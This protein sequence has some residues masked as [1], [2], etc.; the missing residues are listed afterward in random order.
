MAGGRAGDLDGPKGAEIKRL[1]GRRC[2]C[3]RS[4]RYDPKIGWPEKVSGRLLGRTTPK[5]L[6]SDAG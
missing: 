4:W 5:R 6:A 2:P 3:K 1:W